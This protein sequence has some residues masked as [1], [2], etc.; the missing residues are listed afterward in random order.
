MHDQQSSIA[1]GA[2]NRTDRD[3]AV[4]GLRHRRHRLAP[5]QPEGPSRTLGISRDDTGVGNLEVGRALA[6]GGLEDRSGISQV[7]AQG[8]SAYTEQER[9]ERSRESH[10]GIV[11]GGARGVKRDG[12]GYDP[13]MRAAI[14]AVGSEL[15]GTERLDTN[16][17]LLTRVLRRF[18]VQLRS[19]SVVADSEA[20]IA[21]EIRRGVDAND[22]LLVTGG[23]GP[24]ADDVTR[25]AVAQ[26]LGLD[27]AESPEVLAGIERK[28]RSFG[29]RMPAVN[30]KQADVLQGA[31]VLEN[32]RGTAPGQRL[33][34]GD[35]AVF[36]FPGVPTE[37]EFLIE[38]SLLP[39]MREKLG[40]EAIET[41]YLKIACLPESALEEKIQP[42][43][44][45]FDRHD[46]TVLASAGEI[47]LRVTQRGAES[48]RREELRKRVD[49]LE[50]LI[51]DA[52]FG[53]R[54]A[55][56]LEGEV[57][58]LLGVAGRTVVT[59][60]SCTG[61]IVS[62]RLTRVPGSSGYYLGG[63]ITYAD[64]LKL[65]LLGVD[66]ALIVENGAVSEPVV[67]AM[68]AGARTRLGAD[69]S[70][71]ISGV[72]GPGGGSYDKPVGTVHIVVAGPSGA[73]HRELK[74]PG[75]RAR[76]RQLASQWALE[77]LRRQVTSDLERPA[78]R[79]Q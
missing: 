53:R 49:R 50:E 10:P 13:R 47:T 38:S 24:T 28:F 46:L 40:A 54:K 43:Y 72:A 34:R 58:R 62:E 29:M 32:D 51:G 1:P 65:E 67:R 48:E 45:E 3:P 66:P 19:K 79:A 26:A 41:W 23:L 57:G 14:V 56:T 20:D 76:V 9:R 30:R 37:L 71:A 7:R 6:V 12:P 61:G 63:F 59:A 60:E 35:G 31:E 55:A 39:W 18:G 33:D 77:M 22:L 74:L 69:H 73:D 21:A 64:R 25:E 15:L 52:V 11:S 42:F 70:V 44:Q 68:A 16:S 8:Q 5:A 17:L 36:L 27:L 78:M 2:P 75:D 4:N